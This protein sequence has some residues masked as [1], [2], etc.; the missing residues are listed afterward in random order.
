MDIPNA[1]LPGLTP[2]LPN[3]ERAFR[4]DLARDAFTRRVRKSHGGKGE[5]ARALEVRV[6]RSPLTRSEAS[7]AAT[8]PRRGEA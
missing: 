8:S 3:G 6:R 2:P 5:G 4:R 7:F 1:S